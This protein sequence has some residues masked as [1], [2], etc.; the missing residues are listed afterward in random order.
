MFFMFNND[1][2]QDDTVMIRTTDACDGHVIMMVIDDN[3][4]VSSRVVPEDDN[5]I[6]IIMMRLGS[7]VR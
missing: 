4:E 3:D 1:T 2:L 7:S 5:Q 6:Q